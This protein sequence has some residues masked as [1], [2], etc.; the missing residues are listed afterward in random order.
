[1]ASFQQSTRSD[2]KLYTVE[3]KWGIFL[4][5]TWLYFYFLKEIINIPIQTLIFSSWRKM[6]ISQL[7]RG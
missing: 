2:N 4:M 6:I 7:E 5:T 1:M 3:M